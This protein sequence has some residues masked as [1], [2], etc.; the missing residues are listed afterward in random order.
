MKTLPTVANISPPVETDD[1]QTYMFAWLAA[2]RQLMGGS[3]PQS[4]TIA[5]GT[6]TPDE[7]KTF[8]ILVDTEGGAATDDLDRLALT[9]IPDGSHV[10]LQATNTA[11]TVVVRHAQGGSGQFLLVN[12]ANFS[13]DDSEKLI[14]FR[15]SG[16]SF[17]EINRS[18]GADVAAIRAF[19]ALGTAALVNTGTGASDVPTNTQIFDTQR[20]YSRQQ[21]F[22]RQ[23]LTDGAT[24]NWN[25]DTQQV[26]KVTLGGNRTLANPTNKRDGGSY[27][28]WVFQDGTGGRTLSYG[29]DYKWVGGTAPVIG[30]GANDLTILSFESD[31]TIMA[32][33]ALAGYPL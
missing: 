21:R 9:N 28:L 26:A 30:T 7:D 17:I 13:L 23:T 22:V 18:W 8:F 3:V 14:V 24:I 19:L 2:T 11:R 25:L 32:G 31:G 6:F 15:L 12:A 4:K 20:D 16:T 1:M 33:S 10:A 29:S 5:S 27:S